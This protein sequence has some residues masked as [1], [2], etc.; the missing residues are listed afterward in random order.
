MLSGLGMEAPTAATF[1]ESKPSSWNAPL[2]SSWEGAVVDGAAAVTAAQSTVPP[3]MPVL[4]IHRVV[5][6]PSALA[7]MPPQAAVLYSMRSCTGT[8]NTWHL[9]V[10]H[11]GIGR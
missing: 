2:V 9:P 11:C 10:P 8:L 1:V 7:M 4:L 5:M 3:S 6:T